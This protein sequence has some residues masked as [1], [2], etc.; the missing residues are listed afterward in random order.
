MLHHLKCKAKTNQMFT[1]SATGAQVPITAESQLDVSGISLDEK[2]Y[3]KR[4]ITTKFKIL[5]Q[6]VQSLTLEAD[7]LLFASDL[8]QVMLIKS[9]LQ[10]Q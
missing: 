7:H 10:Y 2:Y 4:Q 3:I 8:V 6:K 5:T 1:K 9:K